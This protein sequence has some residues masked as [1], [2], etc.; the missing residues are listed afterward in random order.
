MKGN[1]KEERKKGIKNT[2][3]DKPVEGNGNHFPQ[4]L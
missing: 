1:L 2:N 3:S 4:L